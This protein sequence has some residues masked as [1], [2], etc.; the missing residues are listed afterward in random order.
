MASSVP[1]PQ[2]C[3]PYADRRAYPRV[4]VALPAFLQANGER[5]FVHLLDLSP[6]G[7]KLNCAADLAVGTEV[8]LDCGTLGRAAVVRWRN[9]ELLGLCFESELD[10]RDVAALSQRST[11][12]AARM[13]PNSGTS[14]A[15]PPR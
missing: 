4:T 13:T 3:D 11:A 9:G 12:L 10:A 15:Q 8:V 2:D 6:G 5:H 1:S 7:A 14:P